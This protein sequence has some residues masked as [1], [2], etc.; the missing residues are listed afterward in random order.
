ML[1][2][3]ATAQLSVE[4]RQLALWVPVLFGLGI[5]VYFVQ[6]AEPPAWIGLVLAASAV[7][8][9]FGVAFV[10]A[11]YLLRMALLGIA[12]SCLGFSAAQFRAHTVAAPVLER[13]MTATLEGRILELSRSQRG[14]PRLLLDRVTL[15]GIAPDKTPARVRVTLRKTDSLRDLLPGT[16][17][18]VYARLSPPSGPVEPGGFDFRRF[19]WFDSLGAI[20]LARGAVII[21]PPARDATVLDRLFI[22]VARLRVA[23]AR[24]LRDVLGTEQGGFAAAI[25]IGDRSGIAPETTEALRASNLAHL[26]AISGL[27]MGLLTGFIFALVRYGLGLVPV[28]ALRVDT[29]KAAAVAAML[30]GLAYL[31]MSGATVATQRSYIMVVVILCAVLLNRPAL[32]LRAVALAAMIILVL[33]PESLMHIGFQMSFAATTALVAIYGTVNAQGWLGTRSGFLGQAGAVVLTSLIAGLATAPF[34]AANFHQ[35]APYGLIA[36]VLAVPLMGICIMPAAVIGLL[37]IP[38]GLSDLPLAVMGQ[39]IEVV[40]VIARWVSGMEGA[41]R[42]V[43]SPTAPVLIPLTLGG[44][45]L[46]LWLGRVRL[47]G[48]AG[49]VCGLLWWTV[50][51]DRPDLLVSET[52]KQIGLLT[53]TGRA[54]LDP[55]KERYVAGRWLAADG[56]RV[57]LHEAAQR[58]GILRIKDGSEAA[59]GKWMVRTVTTKKISSERLTSLCQPHTVLIAPKIKTS[60]AGDCIF[61]GAHRLS[62]GGA[63]AVI[64]GTQD[65]TIRAVND[66]PGRLWS[67]Q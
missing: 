18:I 10:S 56:D 59:Y 63:H 40:L 32:T 30:A 12:V 52:G 36:N 46:C 39:G 4:R 11:R 48:I 25:L 7:A 55:R 35:T 44:L 67:R 49:I 27:H 28:I 37:A 33:Q 47:F 51:T 62:D 16:R 41:V 45:W 17:A 38:F 5:W 8:I 64:L 43:V 65:A 3:W 1:L 61:I 23:L 34:A 50:S 19:A 24:H 22:G 26:L 21:A 13:S 53:D 60:P 29:K 31:L 14:L 66:G 54:M 6:V 2:A 9:L 20:G 58:N 42:A 15:H 57:T